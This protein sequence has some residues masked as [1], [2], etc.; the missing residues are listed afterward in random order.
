M[1]GFRETAKDGSFELPPLARSRA[2]Y[3]LEAGAEGYLDWERSGLPAEDNRSLRIVLDRGATVS[4]R[5]LEEETRQPVPGAKVTFLVQGSS[6]SRGVSFDARVDQEGAF[7]EGGLDPGTYTVRAYAKGGSTPPVT[8]SI[9]AAEPHDL[10]ELLLS[11]HPAVKGV[12]VLP[13]N[14]VLSATPSVRL[15][16]YLNFREVSTELNARSLEGSVDGEGAFVI[17]GAAAGRYRLVASDGIWKKTLGPITVDAEDV[18]LGKVQLGKPCSIRGRVVRTDGNSASSW[19]ITLATQAFDFGPPTAFTEEDGSFVF[20]DLAPG[21][22]RLQ[23]YPPLKLMPEADQRV[24]LAPG[25]EAE[26]IVPVG[27]VTVTAFVQVEGRPAGAAKVGLMGQGDAVFDSG[28]VS[29]NSE[30][31]RVI[32]G[33][34][35]IPHLGTADATGLVTIEGVSPGLNQATLHY[36][37]MDYKMPVTIP[38]S[39]QAPPTWSFKGMELTGTV[40]DP[41][42]A[43]APEV[44]VTL[45]YQGVGANPQNTTATD[46]Q[47]NFRM[48]GLGEGTVVLGARNEKGQTAT[49]TVTLTADKPPEPV[50]LKLGAGGRK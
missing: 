37:D 30:W 35:S 23:A 46:G 13:G 38:P 47:G 41:Q 9:T 40:L 10:G 21:V 36:S 39:P 34:P 33:L 43:G 16:R 5:V 6:S 1:D 31:G 32:L 14:E 48:T 28:V 29:V 4:G 44:L 24:E 7:S 20:D 49:A 17:R 26:V 27:G 25:Q 50:V 22:Y 19:R 3:T 11:G 2:P 42:G 12:L 15:E 18:D 8:V 45:G